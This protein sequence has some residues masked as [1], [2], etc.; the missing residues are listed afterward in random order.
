MALRDRGTNCDESL[1]LVMKITNFR[2]SSMLWLFF[3]SAAVVYSTSGFADIGVAELDKEIR[4]HRMGTIIVTGESGTKI[5]VE[6]LRHEFWFGGALAS[7]AFNGHMSS[8]DMA[9]YKSVFLEYFNTGVPEDS[10]KWLDMEPER[11]QIL[12]ST[13]DSMLEWASHNGI[14]MRGHNIFWGIPGRVQPWL[15]ELDDEALREAMEARARDIAQRY[16][17]R[18]T[19]Y[20]LNNEMMWG[21]YYEDRL[22]P[23]IVR[24]MAEWV[25]EED[26][27]AKI[28]LNDYDIL[29]G[30]KLNEFIAHVSDLQGR[31]V[32]I[33]GLGLQGHLHADSFDPEVLSESLDRL[34]E[35]GLPLR[36]TEFNFP[37]QRSSHYQNLELEDLEGYSLDKSLVLSV[38]E[39]LAKAQAIVDY[40]RICFAHPSVTGIMMW[41]FWE[42]ANWIPVAS[43]FRRDWSPTPAALAY[44]QLIFNEWWTSWSGEIGPNGKCEIPAFYGTHKITSFRAVKEVELRKSDKTTTLKLL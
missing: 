11:D 33:D 20:D 9:K 40:Y 19:E 30:R 14:P 35:L 2:F 36:V 32:P 29:S 6:Q 13:T 21:D 15:K 3:V 8:G 22:G 39:E 34:G 5:H 31:G 26:P 24:Q 23:D 10:M 38:D 17:G 16:R 43:L 4:T 27:S 41:G 18:F 37:G 42:E 28:Y 44:R 1:L 7:D 25:L 12:Y